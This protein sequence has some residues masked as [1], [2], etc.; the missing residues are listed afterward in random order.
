MRDREPVALA[1][2]ITEFAATYHL[3]WHEPDRGCVHCG[4][5]VMT[6]D[7]HRCGSCLGEDLRRCPMCLADIA[8]LV[9]REVARRLRQASHEA[10]EAWVAGR[11]AQRIIAA[12]QALDA[13]RRMLQPSAGPR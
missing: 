13:R 3:R 1:E 6:I 8:A 9:D 10:S 2:A 4:E 11:Y 7:D 12:Q 5:R